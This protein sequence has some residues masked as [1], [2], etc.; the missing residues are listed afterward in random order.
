MQVLVTGASGFVGRHV[1]RALLGRGHAVT[2]V[3]RDAAHAAAHDWFPRVRFVAADV[4]APPADL[5][6]AFGDADVVLH[7]AWPGLPNYKAAFHLEQNLPR[8]FAF[9]RA[10]VLAGYRRLLVVGTCL[11]CSPLDGCYTEDM[12]GAPTLPY[13]LAKAR[14][15]RELVGL[16]REHPFTLQWAR[17]FYMYGDGQNP[18]SLLAQL[19]R[20]ID[21]GA[22]SFD[23]SGGEQVRDFSPVTDIARKLVDLV[24]HPEWSGVTHVCSARPVTVRAL[25]E[26]HVAARGAQLALNFGV[27]PYPDYE[28]MAFW[29]VSERFA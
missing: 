13:P 10:L 5:R 29:G 4:H 12:D 11:E 28:P 15:R 23:M 16:Q 21:S 27:Y 2:A 17:L 18:A 24:E 9:L 8:D 25:V 7:L 14:L 20:A 6:A 1:V 26:R 22:A 19:D 3:G